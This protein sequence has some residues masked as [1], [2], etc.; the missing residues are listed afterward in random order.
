ML[1]FFFP[2]ALPSSTAGVVVPLFAPDP[3][4]Q[5]FTTGVLRPLL[6]RRNPLPVYP[7]LKI[8]LV[9]LAAA[10]SAGNASA[11]L[12]FLLVLNDDDDGTAPREGVDEGE[13]R[14]LPAADEDDAHGVCPGLAPMRLAGVGNAGNGLLEDADDQLACWLAVERDDC[15]V[16]LFNFSTR[17]PPRAADPPLKA[18]SVAE[19]G[20]EG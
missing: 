13:A 10:G 5:A 8:V 17:D 18:C 4:P 3:D 7:G 11:R 6:S 12:A 19:P 14:A 15:A 2:A 9:G 20:K 1:P 16:E